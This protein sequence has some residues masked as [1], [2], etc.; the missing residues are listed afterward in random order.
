MVSGVGH[1][2]MK[3]GKPLTPRAGGFAMLPSRHVHQ[4]QCVHPCVLYIYTDEAFDIH[5]VNGRGE[6]IAPAEAM[7]AVKETAATEM[8]K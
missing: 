5:Y 2:E 6:E 1:I 8:K 4:F 3:D 7:K